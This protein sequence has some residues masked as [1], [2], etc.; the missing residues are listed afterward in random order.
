MIWIAD[1]YASEPYPVRLFEMGTGGVITHDK[2]VGEEGFARDRLFVR[3]IHSYIYAVEH[4]RGHMNDYNTFHNGQRV[5]D[6]EGRQGDTG[7][8]DGLLDAWEELHGFDPTLADTAD[9][10]PG[11]PTP[12]DQQASADIQAY[13]ALVNTKDLWRQDWASWLDADNCM[14]YGNPFG[15]WRP[16]KEFYDPTT[17]QMVPLQRLKPIPWEYEAWGPTWNADTTVPPPGKN[18]LRVR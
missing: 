15:Q 3:G 11:D 14:Q 2:G 8:S 18:Y 7:D 10:Y 6:T 16:F 4:E 17:G 9:A 13:G 5:L 12:G 1:N